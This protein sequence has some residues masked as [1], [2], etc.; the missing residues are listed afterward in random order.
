LY[1]FW[2]RVGSSAAGSYSAATWAAVR[3][4]FRR[5]GSGTVCARAALARRRR[6]AH[7]LAASPASAL[8]QLR[9]PS[10]L[11]SARPTRRVSAVPSPNVSPRRNDAQPRSPHGARARLRQASPAASTRRASC[12]PC[13]GHS[14]GP[15]RGTR[16]RTSA[17]SSSATP[18][19]A[20]PT[21]RALS[22]RRCAQLQFGAGS[23]RL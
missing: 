23:S 19:A 3:A 8:L 1:L 13:G 17:R 22:S 18:L 16:R 10:S 11:F 20:P 2:P 12:A 6:D 4:P 5:G 21:A 14:A 15:R 7:L 9:S